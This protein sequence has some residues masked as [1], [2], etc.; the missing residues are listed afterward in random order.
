LELHDA[1]TGSHL[2]VEF[3]A[4]ART[5]YTEAFDSYADSVQKIALRSGGRYVGVSTAQP[6]EEVIF[7]PLVRS[8]GVA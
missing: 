8:R 3:D 1:E 4:S 5:R 7:G 2:K 6:V